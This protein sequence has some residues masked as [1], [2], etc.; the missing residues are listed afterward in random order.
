MAISHF[1]SV[2]IRTVTAWTLW[3]GITVSALNAAD[4]SVK[5]VT[6]YSYLRFGKY[7]VQDSL[8]TYRL[9]DCGGILFFAGGTSTYNA[10]PWISRGSFATTR[11]VAEVNPSTTVGSD[12]DEFTRVGEWVFYAASDGTNGRELWKTNITTLATML[13]KNIR[14]G[15]YSSNPHSL[16]ECNGS[17]VFA[18]NADPT[19]EGDELWISDGTE[20]GT[21]LLNDIAP[22]SYGSRIA[23]PK[24]IGGLTYFNATEFGTFGSQL[25]RTDGTDGGTVLIYDTGNSSHAAYPNTV[26]HFAQHDRVCFFVRDSTSGSRYALWW[27]DGSP[28]GTEVI[29]SP[30]TDSH[31]NGGVTPPDRAVELNG[32]IYFRGGDL[33]TGYELWSSDG[34]AAGT[35]MVADVYNG[36]GGSG[37]H[38]LVVFNDK[39]WFVANDGVRGD[40]IWCSD[41]T[42]AG[43]VIAHEFYNASTS[44]PP[45]P[46]ALEVI[47][48][49]LLFKL[50]TDAYGLE[51]WSTDG[52]EFKLVK[53][54][55]PGGTD[56]VSKD[57]IPYSGEH[58]VV[59]GG[60]YFSGYDPT[61]LRELFRIGTIPR[62]DFQP[63]TMIAAVSEFVGLSI[64][65]AAGLVPSCQWAK[66]NVNIGGATALTYDIS[67]AALSHAGTYKATLTTIDGS[68]TSDPIKLA[69]VNKVLA[70]PQVAQ[71]GTLTL[72][73]GA[74]A[75]SG[76]ALT[77]Q[78][79][80]GGVNLVNGPTSS[81]GVVSGATTSKLTITKASD[82]EEGLYTCT[83]S[84]TPSSLT[85]NAADVKVVGKPAVTSPPVPI[86]MVSGAFSWQLT[87][88]EYPGSFVVSGLPS[89][90]SYNAKTGLV[91]G[92]PNT[93][94]AFK[95]RVYAKNAA[96]SGLTQEFTLNVGALPDGTTGNFTA[97][98]SRRGQINGS[99]GGYMTLKVASAGTFTGTLKNGTASYNL[100]GRLVAPLSGHPTTTVNVKRTSSPVPLS[101][102]LDFDGP[103]NAVT[104]SLDDPNLAGYTG[105]VVTGRRLIWSGTA[106]RAYASAYNSSV[107][108]P[109]GSEN[110]TAQPLGAGWQQMTVTAAGAASGSGRTAEGVAYTFSGSLWPDGSLPQFVLI[111]SSKASVMGL[112][113]ITLGATVP[114]NRV[115]GWVD[116]FKSGPISTTD[117]TYAGG[118]P[119]LERVVDGA[120]WVKPT[121]ALPIVLGRG[122]APGNASIAFSKGGIESAAQFASLAQTFRIN[123]TNTTTFATTTTGNPCN[124]KMTITSSTGL[125]SGGFTL[126]DM[127]SGKAVPR[128]VNYAG[129]LLSHR[130]KGY[131]Y[132]LLPGLTPSTTKAPI[133][134][135]RVVLN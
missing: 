69:V 98:L 36:T 41:G 113:K 75:P 1:S 35:G 131:G 18:C 42:E 40:Q 8:V 74:A 37:V 24:T 68:V 47:G 110:D 26:T 123:K 7:P 134:G 10:E 43:T 125:F 34:T 71:G 44:N 79:Q 21:H 57:T 103:Q 61:I 78:W 106:A 63:D 16:A 45:S 39:V 6:D 55:R 2:C 127:V 92:I 38:D 83:V 135:G 51:W 53:D 60:L 3:L 115:T 22:G 67:S 88:T 132:F 29:A 100:S 59:N 46:H 33:A 17:L 9:S 27:T 121:T 13:V 84:M 5:N 58:I 133:L 65:P 120:P 90:L 122:D 91:S 116:E 117:R 54:V 97:W 52:T 93:S 70:T 119:Y 49:R 81:G 56:G 95:I 80:R 73:V 14:P 87:A 85:T 129:I 30:V 15:N 62:I 94:G 4:F 118:I 102:T 111:S 101:L 19:V 105:A 107:D 86:A 112:P 12:P 109:L 66:N 11:K 25:W 89:G 128:P 31:V 23:N 48:D 99:L 32:R 28:E 50:N 96:G 20:A 124:V 104:G 108:L 64:R 130:N 82:A 76:T 77:Y 72:T 126:S 114:D